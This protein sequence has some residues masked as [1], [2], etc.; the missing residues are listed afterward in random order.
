MSSAAAALL[1]VLVLSQQG[2]HVVS[3]RR[4]I[5]RPFICV[6][7]IVVVSL[8]AAA[9]GGCG[10]VYGGRSPACPLPPSNCSL[11]TNSRSYKTILIRSA[12][13]GIHFLYIFYNH[14][15]EKHKCVILLFVV[16]HSCILKAL[17]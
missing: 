1:L 17:Q 5:L 9:A 14:K 15:I 10:G 4:V 12:F 2:E 16:T 6:R 11:S 8:I 13:R 7:V 3:N